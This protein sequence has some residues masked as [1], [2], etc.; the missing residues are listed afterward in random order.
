MANEEMMAPDR[1]AR[2]NL[3]FGEENLIDGLSS[4]FVK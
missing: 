3:F 1:F 2:V 4:I